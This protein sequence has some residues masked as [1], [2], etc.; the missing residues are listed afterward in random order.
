MHRYQIVGSRLPGVWQKK[1]LKGG[2]G[3]QGKYLSKENLKITTI[4]GSCLPVNVFYIE[5]RVILKK[6]ICCAV[7]GFNSLARN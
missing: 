4:F 5:F 6:Q 1:G 2:G 7:T 3:I